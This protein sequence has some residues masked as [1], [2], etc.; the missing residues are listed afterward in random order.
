MALR[1]RMAYLRKELQELLRFANKIQAAL[2]LGSSKDFPE[3]QRCLAELR[4][5]EHGLRAIEE[6]CHADERAVESTLH[7]FASGAAAHGVGTR[8]DR[9]RFDGVLRRIAVCEGRPDRKSPCAAHGASRAIA[10]AHHLRAE[11]PSKHPKVE[12]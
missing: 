7:H 2:A 1:D 11:S 3:R 5:L 4:E 10:A 9:A 8:R 6:H 12:R